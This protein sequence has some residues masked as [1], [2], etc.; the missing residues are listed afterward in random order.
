VSEK[1]NRKEKLQ[2]VG[3][4]LNLGEETIQTAKIL[5]QQVTDEMDL[6]GPRINNVLATILLMASKQNRLPVTISDIYEGW[7]NIYSEDKIQESFSKKQMGRIERKFTEE[8]EFEIP[9][10]Q[11]DVLVNRYAE[12]LGMPEEMSRTA[13]DILSD[14]H[15]AAPSVITGGRAPSAI[16]ATSLYLAAIVHDERLKYT[17]EVIGEVADTSEL[18]IRNRYP[19]FEEALGGEEQLIKTYQTMEKK[20]IRIQN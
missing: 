6:I 1:R 17:Q 16:A 20:T 9:P 5:F 15:D 8:F 2:I 3:D 14:V 19:E 4:E 7:Y 11:P 13:Q 10:N 18:T 12:E